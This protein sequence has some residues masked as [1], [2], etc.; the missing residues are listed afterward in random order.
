M[1]RQGLCTEPF[2]FCE[3][4]SHISPILFSTV[5]T[6]VVAANR[7]SVLA[8]KCVGGSH[9]S[10]QMFF[11]MLDLPPPVSRNI[12]SKH[13]TVVRE[14]SILQ[15]E[16][17]LRRAR[18]EVREHYGVSSD[19]QVADVLISCDGTWQRRGF[20]S[21]FGAVFIISYETG[22]VL[23][24]IVLSKH[25]AGCRRWEGKDHTT[26][27]FKEWKESHI[28]DINFSGSAGAMEPYGTLKMFQQSLDY[29][30]R[31]KSLIS[32]GDSKTYALLLKEKPY[33]S[34]AEDQVVKMDCVG[35]VQKRMG[36]AL[37]NLKTQHKGRKLSDGKTIGG[38]GRLT[39][40][41]INSLQ[42]YYG[43]AIRRNKGD[44]DSMVRG[45]QATLLHSNSTDDRPRH[46][47]CPAGKDSWCKWQVAKANGEEFH[48]HKNPIPEAILHL[49]K[50]I[51]SRLG[52]LSLLEKCLHG[53]TQNANESLHSV[54]WK[55]CP[56]ELFLGKVSVDT[57]CAMAVCS[58][59]DGATSLSTIASRLGLKPSPFCDHHL[60]RKDAQRIQGSKYKSS[61][62]AKE[63]RRAS[64]RKRKGLDD[65]R[66]EKEGPMYMPGAFDCGEPGPSK[67]PRSN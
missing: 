2:L 28:C 62:R 50:P 11:A 63:L 29:N 37:R 27:A 20:S 23:D 30:V 48:H 55:F 38:A 12:Y 3:N 15:A 65:K 66:Q 5:A 9:A 35:H 7:Q 32:D 51:Y 57:A 41:L 21:L 18:E 47:L 1:K 60:K 39:D 42:N 33:G 40:A 31:F 64:R 67:R 6:K 4:C 26:D 36:T 14:K 46:H 25:C 16:D 58:F 19:D 10:L 8:N 54:V 44:L 13:M 24:Y 45:V 53:Y 56:K 52:S 61:R 22:K 59:N 17:S 43:D 49:L 34:R